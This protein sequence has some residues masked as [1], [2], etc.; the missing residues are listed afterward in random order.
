MSQCGAGSAAERQSRELFQQRPGLLEINRV[1]SLG[2][3]ALDRRQQLAD[4]LTLALVPPESI[5]ADRAAVPAIA[6]TVT[7]GGHGCAETARLFT[8]STSL[9]GGLALGGTHS[10]GEKAST[11][12]YPDS[13]DAQA[14]LITLPADSGRRCSCQLAPP[15]WVPK[16]CPWR[17]QK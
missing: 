10:P 11:R 14:T 12:D 17:V 3:P 2:E 16:T 1:T 4:S 13:R 7:G 9:A 8:P 5:R 6:L 15:S